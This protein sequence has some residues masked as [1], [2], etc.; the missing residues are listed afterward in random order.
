MSRLSPDWNR[1]P[2][3]WDSLPGHRRVCQEGCCKVLHRLVLFTYVTHAPVVACLPLLLSPH[4]VCALRPLTRLCRSGLGGQS[5]HAGAGGVAAGQSLFGARELHEW[6]GR[7]SGPT[8]R[9]RCDAWP[10]LRTS[11]TRRHARTGR[12]V[13]FSRRVEESSWAGSHLCIAERFGWLR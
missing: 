1:D 5:S 11:H 9:V 3:A 2:A 8:T 13:R 10:S 4:A 7:T 6:L 12:G